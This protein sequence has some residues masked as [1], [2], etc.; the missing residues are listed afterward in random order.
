MEQHRRARRV[1]VVNAGARISGAERVLLDLVRSARDRGD[2]VTLVCPPGPLVGQMPAGVTHRPAPVV[3][4]GGARGP[5]R[6]REVAG[7]PLRWLRSARVLRAAARDADAVIVNSTFAL[8]AVG[9]AFPGHGRRSGAPAVRWLVHDT[10][11]SGKQRVVVMLGAHAL[12]GA[13]AVSEVTGESVRGSV[14]EV[15]VQPN[16][17]EVPALMS[18]GTRVTAGAPV[19][20]IL[21]AITPWKGHDVLLEALS[22]LPGVRLEI[23]GTVFPG[24]EAFEE[25]LRARAARPDLAERVSFLGHR[26][27][28][29]V[30]PRWSA[31]VSASTS[32]EAGPLGVLEA[33]AY[34]V[35]VVATD[36]GGAA[37]YLAAGAGALVA[38]AD[39]QA[40][41]AGIRAVLEDPARAELMRNTARARVVEKHDLTRTRGLMLEALS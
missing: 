28:E 1:V 34:G 35:P 18:G 14:R 10:I 16:G 21:A 13:L 19:I 15:R 8:P 17:V 39:A 24:S 4:L 12:T 9:L 23:A 11:T 31:L 32:P 41:A 20:G 2:D 22:E 26:D 6:V 36:H 30:F 29:E 25:D 3:R 38:P 40:L 5:A 7:L 37:E 33:M 27:K